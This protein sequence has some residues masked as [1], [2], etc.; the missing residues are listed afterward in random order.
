M[1]KLLLLLLV[2]TAV[3]APQWDDG[4]D[5]GDDGDWGGDSGEEPV[6]TAKPATTQASTTASGCGR[7]KTSSRIVGG[8][9]ADVNE[10]PWMAV[11]SKKATG[12]LVCG[13]AVI[14]S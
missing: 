8:K 4:D 10:Y 14:N 7:K 12:N 9:N 13:G 5:W 2:G 1:V 6:T 3:G 11:I